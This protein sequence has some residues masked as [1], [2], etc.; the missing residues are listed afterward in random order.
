MVRRTCGGA[1]RFH[2]LNEEWHQCLGV[3]D[4]F[5]LLVEICFVGRAAAFCDAQ[6]AVFH[7]F[8][9]FEVDLRGKVALGVDFLVHG[10]GGILRIAQ[11][12]FR[13][14]LVYA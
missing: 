12:V 1:Q 3:E 2:F 6:E 10:K 5:C 9:R 14:G 11:V 7:A 4:G 8:G 13:V